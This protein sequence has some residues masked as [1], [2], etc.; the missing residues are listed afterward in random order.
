MRSRKQHIWAP[1]L[2]AKIPAILAPFFQFR[3]KTWRVAREQ[4]CLMNLLR[5]LP[6]LDSKNENKRYY[7]CS[8]TT[9][10]CIQHRCELTYW[11][12][13]PYSCT[14]S[15]WEPALWTSLSSGLTCSNKHTVQEFFSFTMVDKE[16]PTLVKSNRQHI[17]APKLG[18]IF[19]E[20]LAPFFKF[21][22]KTWRI[23]RERGQS[24]GCLRFFTVTGLKQ[25]WMGRHMS[26]M[27]MVSGIPYRS[28]GD[29]IGRQSIRSTNQP[30]AWIDRRS[31]FL[32]C[33]QV[34][35]WWTVDRSFLS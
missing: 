8:N 20:I 28:K 18:A 19:A 12:S 32:D 29:K 24:M 27:S 6:E 5:L 21:R 1:K 26:M 34:Q 25:G 15:P 33:G 2:G 3:T 22:T 30:W 11:N 13:T 4:R 16:H 7:T 23:G 10:S 35:K 17:W 9:T 31:R 14:R